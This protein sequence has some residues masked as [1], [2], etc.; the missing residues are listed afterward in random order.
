MQQKPQLYGTVLADPPWPVR[1]GRNGK[2]GW[3]RSASPHAHY[4]L[5]KVSEIAALPVSQVVLPDSHLYLWVVNGL[6]QEG[7]DVMRAW[8]FRYVNNIC[9]GKTSGYGLGQYWRGEHE[10]CLFGIRGRTPY[11]KDQAGKRLQSRSLILA[12]RGEHS[13]KPEELHRRIER[14][15]YGPYLELFARRKVNGWHSWGNTV[16]NDVKLLP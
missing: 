4:P 2:S 13:E 3:S 5:M 9:W 8:G 11:K 6:L 1:G 15:S 12:D 7:L 16:P 14:V 10:L